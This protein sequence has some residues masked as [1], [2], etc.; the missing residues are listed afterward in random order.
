VTKR[1]IILFIFF[2]FSHAYSGQQAPLSG[3]F[4]ATA[5][6]H[7]AFNSGSFFLERINVISDIP[8]SRFEFDHLSHLREQTTTTV[9]AVEAA[10]ELL[11]MRKRFSAIAIDIS[12][13]KQGKILDFTLTGAW[14]L[15]KIEV[16]G[17]WFGK[18]IFSSQ[19]LQQPGEIFDQHHHEQSLKVIAKYLHTRGYFQAIVRDTITRKTS[20]KSVTVTLKIKSG[21][22]FFVRD[23]TIQLSNATLEAKLHAVITAQAQTL[24]EK[25]YTK[26]SAVQVIKSMK[27]ALQNYG[28]M[29]PRI[30]LGKKLN[31]TKHTIDLTFSVQPGLV[32]Q[33]SF[34]GN[35][36]LNENALREAFL[37]P[38]TPA[39]LYAPDILSQQL[40][41]D[42]Y[43]KGFWHAKVS[44]KEVANKFHFIIQENDPVYVEKVEVINA[45]LHTF[46]NAPF[47]QKR[48]V[49]QR[50]DQALLDASLD[51]FK[52][53]HLHNGFWDFKIVSKDFIKNKTTGRYTLAVT[54][55]KG[56]QRI[57]TGTAIQEYPELEDSEFFKKY[58]TAAQKLAPFDMS[59]LHAQRLFL[60]SHFHKLGYWYAEAHPNLTLDQQHKTSDKKAE[61]EHI[62]LTWEIDEGPKVCFGPTVMRGSTRIPFKRIKDQLSIHE[63]QPW[64]RKKIDASRKH[65]RAL[66]VFKTVL[67]HP[68]QLAQHESKKPTFITLVDDDPFEMR[69]RAGYSVNTRNAFFEIR[70]TPKFGASF[71]AKNPTNR[72]DKLVLNS[73]W[74]IFE[75]KITADYQ[76]PSPFGFPFM[77]NA[78]AFVTKTQHP[79]Q[80]AKSKSAY[81]ALQ[82][83]L[84]ASVHD[85]FKSAFQWNISV[86][87]EWAKITRVEGNLKFDKNLVNRVMP[88]FFVQPSF[89]IDRLDDRINTTDGTLSSLSIRFMVPETAGATLTKITLEQSA[90]LPVV[91]NLI[92]AGRV[93]AGHIFQSNF[94]QLLPTERFYLGGPDS[95]R[96]YEIDSLPPIGTSIVTK[97]GVSATHYTIQGGSSMV[98]ANLEL[99]INV[100]KYFGVVVFQDI[101]ILSQTGFAGFK[102]TWYPG[103]GL[104]VRFKTPIGALR[105]DAGWKWKRR[106]EK[107]SMHPILYFTFSEA[108]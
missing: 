63:D 60:L 18:S 5:Q 106:L 97:D 39:W 40:L 10:Y 92:L 38:D 72:A 37:E 61:Q 14:V 52:A 22:R 34:E 28:Y 56:T 15:K 65:L 75:N 85:E 93:R 11:C 87:N 101:G 76:Q 58:H 94:N 95:V 43:K 42:Y 104:G 102:G 100:H 69:F 2:I 62:F 1:S 103:S 90:F 67:V 23:A 19:Y 12:D 36:V 83:G 4:A 99:R 84:A 73:N 8:F 98:N 44:T 47:L 9:K 7:K 91:D 25:I 80:I 24:Q 26:D 3:S 49:G 81:E 74:N 71:I 86:G 41:Y 35:T 82:W 48:L 53:M 64:D 96:G 6:Q 31:T 68:A 33:F 59:W 57:L 105:L 55:D 21:H 30:K 32:R 51:S 77:S 88:Y 78:G 50:C 29:N 45:A 70:D 108:F 46:E 66:D 17:I 54:I 79:V 13:G 16:Q 27:T 89:T 20:D 107:D